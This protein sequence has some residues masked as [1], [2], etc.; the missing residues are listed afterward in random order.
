MGAYYKIARAVHESQGLRAAVP[1]YERAAAEDRD[2]GMPW[3]Y[4]GYAYKER[5]QKARAVQEFKA[6]LS[7]RPD[8]DDR[9]DVEREIEDLGG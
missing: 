5:G 2:N 4:L 3:L 8:A 7:K 1:W 9:R 6:Y